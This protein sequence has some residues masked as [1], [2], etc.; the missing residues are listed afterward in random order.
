MIEKLSKSLR[1]SSDEQ[2]ANAAVA[3]LLEKNRTLSTLFVKRV[4]N[5]TDPWA[6][7]IALPG[8]KR[9]EEDSN[10]K[11]TVIRETLEETAIDLRD[12][13]H[14][15]GVMP[16]QESKPRPEIKVLPFVVLLEYA[17]TIRLNQRE[18]EEYVWIPVDKLARSRATAT[19]SFG[20]FP[21]YVV[22]GI[23]IW[24]LTYRIIEDFMQMLKP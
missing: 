9:E 5:P 18:L 3:V 4:Q 12:R 15:L 14:F 16:A 1:E 20:K 6:G 8:G 7:Q 21:A 13:C 19:L 17:P 22:G 2:H 24:G 11:Q 23:T 10:L